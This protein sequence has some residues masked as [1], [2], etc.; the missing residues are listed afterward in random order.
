MRVSTSGGEGRCGRRPAG[1]R[2]RRCVIKE[3]VPR[4]EEEEEECS[5]E[6]EVNRVAGFCVSSAFLDYRSL[7]YGAA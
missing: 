3:V 4:E 7:T 5:V 1:D 2:R 6:V